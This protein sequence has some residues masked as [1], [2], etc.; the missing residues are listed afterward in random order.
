MQRRQSHALQALYLR[1]RDVGVEHWLRKAD[2]QAGMSLPSA[3]LCLATQ[4]VG[5][6][7]YRLTNLIVSSVQ[8]L[9]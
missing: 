8:R 4:E 9:V 7:L 1:V 3:F 5:P 6:V 2:Q